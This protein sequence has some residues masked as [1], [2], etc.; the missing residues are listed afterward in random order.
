MKNRIFTV[1][2]LLGIS[3]SS[4]AQ[5]TDIEVTGSFSSAGSLKYA[6][7]KANGFGGGIKVNFK[8][9]DN[10]YISLAAGYQSYSI[11][12]D[13]ALTQWRWNFWDNRY[14]GSIRADLTDTAKYKLTITPT[15][16]IHA[17]PVSVLIG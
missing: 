11:D 6:V 4:K 12:Q 7:T 15:Q 3:F 14:Y 5:L 17:I 9:F 13:S 8:T 2:L 16:G 10:F 1:L